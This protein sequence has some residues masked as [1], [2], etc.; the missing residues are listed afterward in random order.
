MQ[1]ILVICFV[2]KNAN[3]CFHFFCSSSSVFPAVS[4]GFT[5]FG[6]IFAYVT[7]FLCNHRGNHIPSSWMLHA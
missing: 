2:L 6:E 3:N 4:L 5:I 7:F 1:V